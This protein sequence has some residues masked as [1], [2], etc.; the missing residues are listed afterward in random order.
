MLNTHSPDYVNRRKIYEKCFSINKMD[1]VWKK[2]VKNGLRSQALLDLHDYYDFHRN[3]YELFK[4]IKEQIELGLYK[5]QVPLVA[6][7]EKKLGVCRH[8][9]IPR[10]EDAVILQT[11]VESI[12]TDILKAS[13]TKRSYYS[14]SHMPFKKESEIDA[15]FPYEWWELW[16]EFQERI[17]TF[18]NT[19][20]FVAVTDISNYFDC[21]SLAR[22]RSVVA[23]YGTFD[24]ALLD[25]LFFVLESQIWHPDYLP[26]KGIGLPQINFDAPR[27]LAHGFLFGIDKYLSEMTNKNFVRWMDDIDFG[28]NNYDEAKKILKDLD[29]LLLTKGLRLNLG[30]TTILSSQKAKDYFL[31]DENRYLTVLTT[32]IK[33]CLDN[34]FDNQDNIKR[35]KKRY[36]VFLKRPRIGRWEKVYARYFTIASLCKDDFLCK[37]SLDL[38]RNS[39]GLRRHIFKYFVNLGYNRKRFNQLRDFIMGPHSTDDVSVF[40]ASKTVTDWCIKPNASVIKDIVALALWIP[41]NKPN[42]LVSSFWLLAKYGKVKE[43]F[44]VVEANSNRWLHSNFLS[45]QVAALVPL[46]RPTKKYYTFVIESLAKAGKDEALKVVYNL[47]DIRKWK[48]A[49]SDNMYLLHGEKKVKTYPLGK[50][51]VAIDVLSSGKTSARYRNQLREKIAERIPDP[52]FTH[53]LGKIKIEKN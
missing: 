23:S 44:R 18:S 4:T 8:I 3:R 15:S 51:L 5:P 22:L 33:R 10:P 28:V 14:R 43:L 20:Q 13:P 53:R 40:Y 29:E 6:R 34:G 26:S 17:Y 50:F 42:C 2:Y 11:L 52:L 36:R 41:A 7:I 35:L 49:P 12:I 46:F 48:L 30:K 37:H 19:F 27:L 25:L 31:A 47:N 1:S 24:E 45:R 39:P 32:R 16:P 38:L 21:V 9:V